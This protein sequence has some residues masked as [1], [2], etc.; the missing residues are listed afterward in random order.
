MIRTLL[1]A[2]L[3]LLVASTAAAQRGAPADAS[4]TTA[5]LLTIERA[6]LLPEAI[7]SFGACRSGRWLYVYGGHIGR[8]HAHSRDHVVGAFRRLDLTDGATW[9]DLPDGPALQGTA[10]VAG[11]DGAVYRVGGMTARNAAG[12]DEDL[13]STASVARFDAPTGRWEELTPLPEARSSHDAVV[14]GHQLFVVGGWTLHG[15]H[16]GTW[17]DTAWVADLRRQP[18]EWRSVPSPKLQRRALALA[19]FDGRV[20]ALGGM[21]DDQP[22]AAVQ[23]FDPAT[24][25]WCD[26]PPL[27]GMAFGTA[28]VAVDGWLHA[29][30][31]DG[32]VLR[33]NGSGDWQPLTRLATPRFFHRL[34]HDDDR[35]TLIALGGASRGGHLRTVEQLTVASTIA[36]AGPSRASCREYVL[37]A[38]GEVAHRQAL[39]VHDDTLWAFGGNRGRDGDRFAPGQFADDIWRIDLTTMT[40]SRDGALPFAAQSLA[41]APLGARGEQWLVGGLGVDAGAGANGATSLGG[42]LRWR[43][44]RGPPQALPPLPAPRTQCRLLG[45]DGRLYLIG[46]VDFRPDADGGT[47]GDDCCEVLVC[48]PTADEPRFAPSGIRL[49]R[50]RRS[51]GAALHGTRLLLIGGLGDGFEH[52]G[53]GDVYDFAT[54]RWSELSTPVAW[55]SPQV[56]TIG[57]RTFVGCGGTMRGQRFTEDR[58]LH[59]LES[60]GSWRAL[61][62]LPFATRHVQMFARHERLWFYDAADSVARRVVLREFAPLPVDVDACVVR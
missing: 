27:P 50:P 52:A 29:T 31:M 28:A 38:P 25:A 49:P 23:V 60:D 47:T 46:G 7:A 10:L 45:Y 22:T 21:V 9:Q 56:A 37:A 34:V 14:L 6:P 19:A 5:P 59:V 61:A 42:V 62:T 32:R 30:V 13:H 33:W 26:G 40:A 16:D 17:L 43:P 51:F 4:L 11:P 48:D 3:P 15:G 44:R 41:I 2:A 39:A 55:V 35:Q 18:L 57:D 36:A 24:G 8:A 20:V 1:S 54:G 12:D 58:V 53:S